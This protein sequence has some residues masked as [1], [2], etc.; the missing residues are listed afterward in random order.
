MNAASRRRL[1]RALL[2]RLVAAGEGAGNEEG[3]RVARE[4]EE[5]LAAVQDGAS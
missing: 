2:L 4:A 1:L 5:A 3:D